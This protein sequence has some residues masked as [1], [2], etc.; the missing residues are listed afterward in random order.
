MDYNSL[1]DQKPDQEFFYSNYPGSKLMVGNVSLKNA[2][3]RLGKSEYYVLVT[4][5]DGEQL[6]RQ[7]RPLEGLTSEDGTLFATV[8]ND[9]YTP[10][11][12]RN[13]GIQRASR[14]PDY[15]NS[16]NYL[17]GPGPETVVLDDLIE[18]QYEEYKKQHGESRSGR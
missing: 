8:S 12:C 6:P 16:A 10:Y 11:I 3:A 13:G 5:K 4:Y 9:V 15:G 17:L 18:E 14:L 7:Y 1:F 2:Q